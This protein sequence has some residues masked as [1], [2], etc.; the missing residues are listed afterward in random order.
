MY[1]YMFMVTFL[2][3]QI[4]YSLEICESMLLILLGSGIYGSFYRYIYIH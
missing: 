4:L 3:I 1:T 2:D